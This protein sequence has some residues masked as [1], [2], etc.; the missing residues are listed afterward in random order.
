MEYKTLPS[1]GQVPILTSAVYNSTT[2]SLQFKFLITFLA[3]LQ[4]RETHLST[5]KMQYSVI[6]LSALAATGELAAATRSSNN[7]FDNSI[8]VILQ[9][10]NPELGSQTQFT[11]CQRETKSPVGSSG[12]FRAVELSLGPNVKQ[13]DLRC[14]I[15]DKRKDPIV[16]VRGQNVDITFSDGDKGEWVFK[17]RAAEVSEIICDPSFVKGLA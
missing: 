1:P 15:L 17:D 7:N 3:S 10:Q 2:P 13:K 5:A 16:V 11:E 14:Q 12:P 9:N 4:V 8:T 6:L